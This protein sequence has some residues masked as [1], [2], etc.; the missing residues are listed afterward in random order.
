MMRVRTVLGD[1]DP[2]ELG[3]TNY[4][5]HLFQVSPLL[6]GDDLDDE[7]RST[8]EARTLLHSGFGAMVDATPIGLGRRPQALARISAQL[9]LHIVATTGLHREAHYA[10]ADGLFRASSEQVTQRLVRDVVQGMPA[11]DLAEFTD[12]NGIQPA[13]AEPVASA[14]GEPI[15]AGMLKA[16]IGYW[17]MSAFERTVLAA[18]AA[19]HIRTDAP[20]M[21]HLEHGSAAHEVLDLL[22]HAGVDPS[23]VVLAHIDRNPDAGLHAELAARGAYLGYDGAART[24]SW[25]D[26]TLIDCL[27]AAADRGASQRIVL[28]GDVARSSRY[29]AYGGLPGLGYLGNRFLPR[30]R[31]AGGNELADSCVIGN[32]QRLLGRFGESLPQSA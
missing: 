20:V 22:E 5:E 24:R 31:A 1:V 10:G 16:G 28:G 26:S 29:L 6:P 14:I 12:C 32:P 7:A 19:A 13:T 25:P 15:R 27:I 4:H 3:P 17:S 18:V 23:A 30:L 21:V 11:T 2:V 9:G 8:D